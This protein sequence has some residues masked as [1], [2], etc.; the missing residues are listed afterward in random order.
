MLLSTFVEE[1]CLFTESQ[2]C[3]LRVCNPDLR[4]ASF[5]VADV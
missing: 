4:A 5:V 3:M 2:M 1:L